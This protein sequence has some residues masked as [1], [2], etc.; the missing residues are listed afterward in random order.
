MDLVILQ[1][2][3]SGSGKSS[4]LRLL[5]RFYDPQRGS[6]RIDGQDISKVT[7]LRLWKVKHVNIHSFIKTISERIFPLKAICYFRGFARDFLSVLPGSQEID[8]EHVQRTCVNI[9]EQESAGEPQSYCCFYFFIL[10]SSTWS[11]WQVMIGGQ[12]NSSQLLGGVK[13]PQHRCKVSYQ[14]THFK[15]IFPFCFLR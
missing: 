12:G 2:G 10:N 6:I 13:I 8:N 9:C 11:L 15:A 1:V 7:L 5:F 4:I 3:P 14:R